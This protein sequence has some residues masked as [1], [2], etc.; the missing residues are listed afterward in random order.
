MLAEIRFIHVLLGGPLLVAIIAVTI[1]WM[2]G[3]G[4]SKE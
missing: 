4:K 1:Y 2:V 3:L